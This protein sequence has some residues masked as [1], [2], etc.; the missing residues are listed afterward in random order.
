M[1]GGGWC[2]DPMNCYWRAYEAPAVLGSSLNWS[3]PH[4]VD[5]ATMPNPTNDWNIGDFGLLDQDSEKNPEFYDWTAVWMR[6]VRRH[7]RTSTCAHTHTRT[8]SRTAMCPRSRLTPRSLRTHAQ[9]LRRILVHVRSRRARV[10][11]PVKVQLQRSPL[12]RSPEARVDAWACHLRSPFRR[13][14]ARAGDGHGV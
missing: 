11:R 1:S 5:N 3:R 2:Q 7:S 13:S 9:V 12:R 14:L 6:F 10:D 8:L 4:P